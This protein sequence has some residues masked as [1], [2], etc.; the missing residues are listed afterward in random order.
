MEDGRTEIV[1]PRYYALDCIPTP[2]GEV[3][4]IDVQGGVGG[5][6]ASLAAAYGGGAAARARLRPYLESL[7]K[8]AAGK[9]VLFVH[10]P[11]SIRQPFPDDFFHWVHR[12][13]RYGPITDWVPDLAEHSRQPTEPGRVPELDQMGA[14]L[15]P[16]ASRL[17]IRIGY[18]TVAR[19]DRQNGSPMVLLSGY[20]ERARR[21]G[22]SV[23]LPPEEIG[24]VVFSG[25]SERFPDDLRTQT[26]FPVVN[27]PLLDRLLE[28]KWLLPTLLEGTPAARLL[29]GWIPV[30]V[31]LRSAAEIREYSAN[32]Q[33]PSGFP[34]AVLKPSHASLSPGIRYLDRT[35]L[36]ALAARQPEQRISASDLKELLNPRIAHSYDELSAYN[37]KQL[38]NLLRTPGARV[39]DHRDGT[40][41]YS[42]PYPFLETTVAMLRD[43][44]ES[45]P[46]KSRR[47]GKLHRGALRVVMLGSA[48]VAAVYRLDQEPDDGR[49]RDLARP[50]LPTFVEAAS[51]D[52]EARLQEQ[53]APFVDELDRQFNA[54]VRT[55]SDLARLRDN[56]VM[57][58][59]APE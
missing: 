55:R 47:T 29:P 53:L 6:L 50:D 46:I 32:L 37:G 5:G 51:L 15:D 1:T 57:S 56:W 45:R 20:R 39:H 3:R 38:D 35:A 19:V 12:F 30:G 48:V 31:G 44:I 8:V 33:S 22:T 18:C 25:A 4:V 28:C 16:I 17:K 27:P 23:I 58:Q 40:F 36:K 7:G 14:I 26:W 42:A 24:V 13:A 43:F 41:H 52:D 59:S 34:V 9:R 2:D 54:R 11:F 10:D 21:Q 49:F